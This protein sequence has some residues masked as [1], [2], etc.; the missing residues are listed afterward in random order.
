MGLSVVITAAGHSRRM[1]GGNKLLLPL[2]GEPILVHTVRAFQR[3][4]LVEGIVVSAPAG[5]EEDYRRLFAQYGLTAVKRVVT[6]GAERQN[7]IFEALQSFVDAAPA[8]IAVH[9]GARPVI[10]SDLISQLYEALPG[11][12]GVVPCLPVKDTIKRVAQNG[13]VVETLVRAELVAV[14]T[15]QLFPYAGL[16]QAYERCLAQSY[17]GT[18]DASLVEK[19]GGRVLACPGDYHNIK[20]TTAEDLSLAEQYLQEVGV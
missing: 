5:Q 19:C 10:T 4:P 15:P 12:D 2:G 7:S 8:C 6:G 9:D 1:G 3:H 18:D 20:V 11:W 14:Q 17:L 16:M 13:E